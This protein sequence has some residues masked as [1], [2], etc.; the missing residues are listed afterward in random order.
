MRR[1]APRGI[2]R[3]R[4]GGRLLVVRGSLP[5][6]PQDYH[7]CWGSLQCG[8][9]R[10]RAL[11]FF[12]TCLPR[13]GYLDLGSLRAL[14]PKPNPRPSSRPAHAGKR[15]FAVRHES[16]I[17]ISFEGSEGCGKST[18]ISRLADRLEE[19]DHRDVV[20]TRE[21]GGTIIGE[22]IRHLLMHADSSQ[23]IFPETELLLFAASRAQ[24]VRELILPAV[25]EGKIVL[26]D[27][28]LDST[29]VYQGVARQI[30]DD[31]ITQI[32]GFAVGE[33]IPDL[34]IVLDVPA[35]VG[36]AFCFLCQ[37]LCR[38]R[39]QS[40]G[41]HLDRPFVADPAAAPLGGVPAPFTL[42]FNS[43]GCDTFLRIFY[44][45]RSFT[46]TFKVCTLWE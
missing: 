40:K 10:S 15:V 28:F 18:Q 19:I 35:E 2:G 45:P 43:G 25:R 5:R 11:R 13:L 42:T 36:L 37:A 7:R 4:H 31:P 16:G 38:E 20:V 9:L 14:S 29:T 3:L 44:R 24:L 46:L 26:C 34:T 39:I 41:A 21:P 23:S 22:D 17:L 1:R 30:A 6:E 32:N 27:R 12:P 33:M 8:L